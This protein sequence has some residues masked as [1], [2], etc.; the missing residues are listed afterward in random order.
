MHTTNS[1]SEF[2]TRYYQIKQ[3]QTGVWTVNSSAGSYVAVLGTDPAPTVKTTI[4]QNGTGY[5][6]TWQIS[7]DDA[8]SSEG[9]LLQAYNGDGHYVTFASNLA[10]SGS[11]NWLPEVLPSGRYTVELVVESGV[12][13]LIQP[14]GV[15][16][17]QD[18]VAPQSPAN[19]TIHAGID[20]VLSIEWQPADAETDGYR[21]QINGGSTIELMGRQRNNFQKG[22]YEAGQSVTVN[23][24]AVDLSGN[25]S[26]PA[27]SSTSWATSAVAVQSLFPGD[28]DQVGQD[29]SKVEILFSQPVTV[30]NISVTDPSGKAM[31]GVFELITLNAH[32]DELKAIGAAWTSSNGT[33]R[34]AGDYRATVQGVDQTGQ[35]VEI[36]WQWTVVDGLTGG[37]VTN[38]MIYLPLIAKQNQ[39]DKAAKMSEVEVTEVVYLPLVTR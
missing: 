31:S 26:Q 3:P 37:E 24:W 17:W 23:V 7:D 2:N 11:F 22:G 13:S 35:S 36:I 4:Q 6:I 18:K 34:Q 28:R 27:S 19:L 9:I 15:I 32:A 10:S 5:A 38:S 1:S 16:D 14:V 30:S 20:G 21:V 33:L 29:Q 25:L 39:G 8:L 12:H